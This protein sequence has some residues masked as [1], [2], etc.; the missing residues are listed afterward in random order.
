MNQRYGTRVSF[1]TLSEMALKGLAESESEVEQSNEVRSQFGMDVSLF[2]ERNKASSFEH[3]S[4]KKRKFCEMSHSASDRAS[5]PGKKG[6]GL[7]I[8]IHQA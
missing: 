3:P 7:R 6:S 2:L 5:T 4:R 8:K 1:C